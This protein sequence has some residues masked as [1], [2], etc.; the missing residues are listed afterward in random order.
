MNQSINTDSKNSKEPQQK[1][2]LGM[3]SMKILGGL[4]RFYGRP[5]SPS[6]SNHRKESLI[7]WY[8][9]S[10][11]LLHH[12]MGEIEGVKGAWGYVEGGM[13][14]VSA[15]IANCATDHGASIFTDKVSN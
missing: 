15:A 2:R 5:T 13:G 6:E 14:S 8:Y 11:V 1:Y 12:V 7:H 4:N 9:C 10:Y 3:V